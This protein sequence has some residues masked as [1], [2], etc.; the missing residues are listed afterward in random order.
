MA[1]NIVNLDIQKDPTKDPK[2]KSI[3]YDENE[4]PEYKT[5]IELTDE[6]KTRIVKEIEAELAAIDKE[7]D[8]AGLLDKWD[9]LDKQYEGE[10][11]EI[12]NMQFSVAVK[13]TAIKINAVV[14]SMMEAFFEGDQI[15]TATAR[16]DFADEEN[17]DDILEKQA[18]FLDYKI[19]EV[20]PL[21][22]EMCLVAHSA[23]L[24]NGGILKLS[25]KHKRRPRK[26]EECYKGDE[27][28]LKSFL[29]AYPSAETEYPEY[30]KA[31]KAGKDLKLIVKYDEI[32]Y[33]DPLPQYVDLKN[34]RIRLNT[35]G[36]DGFRDAYLKAERK[37]YTYWQLLQE[38]KEERL[39]DIDKLTYKQSDDKNSAPVRIDNY[40]NEIYYLWECVFWTKLPG[41]DEYTECVFHI[42]RERQTM[43]G[44]FN[45]PYWGVDTYYIP[46]YVKRKKK[47][48]FQPGI[49]EDLTDSN[50]VENMLLC[51][52][53]EGA[54]ASNLITPITRKGSIVAQQ[55]KEKRWTHGVPLEY[56]NKNEM[57]DFLSKYM[58]PSNT[59]ELLGLLTYL[60]QGQGE[61]SGVNESFATGNADPIDPTAPASKTRDLLQQSGLNIRDYMKRFAMSFNYLGAALMSMYYQRGQDQFKY[62][63]PPEQTALG[64]VNPFATISRAEMSAKTNFQTQALVFDTD[65]LT[66]KKEDYALYQIMRSEPL[67]A[68]NEEQVYNLVRNIIKGWSPKWRNNINKIFP[69]LEEFKK[70]RLLVAVAAIKVYVEQQKA[71][72][73]ATNVAPDPNPAGLLD[74]MNTM[75]K[76]MATPPS[77]EEIKQ[78][79]AEAKGE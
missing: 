30:V 72:A 26:M 65:K 27:E 33:D 6:E 32:V 74:I 34:F 73:A 78:R 70:Q 69:P 11:R 46:F 19:D 24:K 38:E 16:P 68:R 62:R 44:S 4:I 17:M 57:P 9:A 15:F 18:N 71:I 1:E 20:I 76:E 43:H 55:F 3:E 25:M 12:E 2:K 59:A 7:Y 60:K 36:L 56:E 22:E 40:A 49:G 79:E 50:L 75:L 37:E 21:E 67:I 45:Y 42:N 54:Y 64:K 35:D 29:R 61:V 23:T 13:T 66:A 58:K 10:M 63:L 53:L 52:L 8:A 28:G 48:A 51:F 47:G 39:Y 31:L 5:E 41:S 77:E 14:R